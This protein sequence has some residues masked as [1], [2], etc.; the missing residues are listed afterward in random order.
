MKYSVLMSVYRND[1]PE[2]LALAL[3]SIYEEQTRKP[4]EIIIVFDGPLT[5]KLYNVLDDFKKDKSEVVRFIKQDNNSGLGEALRVGSEF[6][7]GDYIFRMDSDD[8]SDVR[9]FERQITYIEEHPDI[10]VLGS[11]IAE[12]ES[13]ID[14]SKRVRACPSKHND[15]VNMGKTRNPMNHVTV[16]IKRTAL[17]DS[18]GYENL[19]LVEDYYLWLKMIV[20]GFKFA[21]L[22]ETL[23]Y[24]RIGN[25]FNE[26]RGSSV[27]VKGW[28][29]IQKYMLEHNMINWFQARL[30]MIYIRAF[31]CCPDA[32]RK[33]AYDKI[34]RK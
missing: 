27:R 12:F 23:V 25:G 20:S 14:E 31:T 7:T 4:D 2:H 6:C 17:A 22:N 26:K 11:D 5:E 21:N 8:I 1:N 19:L 32:L 34:L 9:R 16:C 33:F 10:D 3:K 30:N 29:V 28:K 24:V 13:S 18:G 15:I